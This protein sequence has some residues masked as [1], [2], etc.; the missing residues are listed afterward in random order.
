[1]S[2]TSRKL[3]H[4]ISVSGQ[5]S[6]GDMV[7]LKASG[8]ALII[9]NRPDH[10]EPEQPTGAEIEAAARAAGMRYLAVPVSGAPDAHAAAEMAAALHDLGPG[11]GAHLYC[12]SGMRSASA[13]A[14]AQRLAG[15]DADALRE[16]A[17][18]AGYDLGRLPL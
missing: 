10:E 14:M 2:V 11:D 9:N 3:T 6:P 15:V 16:A 13:W 8:V 7:A 1:M 5:I 18:G 12:R 4:Q 17:A